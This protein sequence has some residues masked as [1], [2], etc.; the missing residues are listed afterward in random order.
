MKHH[1]TNHV[2]GALLQC[3]RACKCYDKINWILN[4]LEKFALQP[5]QRLVGILI[6]AAQETQDAK[7]A[8]YI[9][10]KLSKR[11]WKLTLNCIDCT[12]LIK[13][14]TSKVL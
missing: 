9:L 3:C 2:L 14:L 6:N 1:P 4:E 7:L 12:Q 8:R 11:E 13:A 5:N 10:D